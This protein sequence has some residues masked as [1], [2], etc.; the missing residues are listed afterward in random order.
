[1]SR[2]WNFVQAM[3]PGDLARGEDVNTNLSGIDTALGLV[4]AE[5]NEAIRVSTGSGDFNIA[6]NIAA[7][8]NKLIAFDS[9]GGVVASTSVGIYQGDFAAGDY[10][11]RDIVRDAGAE[12][13]LNNLY[14]C[15]TAYTSAGDL[16]TEI[17]NWDLVINVVDVEI[18]RAAAVV[19]QGLA[20]AAEDAA[21][22]EKTY[23]EEWSQKAEDTAVSAS[24]GG[25]AGEYSAL[26]HSA[27]S[28]GH[29]NDSATAQGLAEDAQA[30]AE[31]VGDQLNGYLA[32]TYNANIVI[33]LDGE[34]TRYVQMTGAFSTMAT[35]GRA[36]GESIT[37]ILYASGGNRTLNYNSNWQQIG[38]LPTTLL[39]GKYMVLSL[40]CLGPNES[41]VLIAGATEL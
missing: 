17:A 39:S 8:A 32:I 20:E 38:Y 29:A 6:D 23:A 33:P 11:V 31:L 40:I 1:M 4:Q 15:N 35:S 18:A 13:G 25:G 30:A 9:A 2:F 21:A 16:A 12:V 41:N 37:L 7:R 27:K 24:A 22:L 26:H 36:A 14:I 19:A 3:V 34:Q 10:D 28:L 5:L